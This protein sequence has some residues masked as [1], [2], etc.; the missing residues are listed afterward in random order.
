M[1]ISAMGDIVTLNI[2]VVS[3]RCL[4]ALKTT[5]SEGLCA[6]H[7]M[8]SQLSLASEIILPREESTSAP[9]LH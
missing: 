5:Q 3:N 8:Y 9:F 4:T 7:N 2:L 1:K 6:S